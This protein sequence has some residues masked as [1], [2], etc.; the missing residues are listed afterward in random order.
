MKKIQCEVCNIEL[1]DSDWESHIDTNEHKEKTLTQI[2]E[3]RIGKE[4]SPDIR[5]ETTEILEE[6]ELEHKDGSDGIKSE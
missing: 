2:M 5:D 4:I 6:L 1:D 3:D